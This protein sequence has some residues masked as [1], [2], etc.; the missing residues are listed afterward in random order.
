[1]H[2]ERFYLERALFDPPRGREQKYYNLIQFVF[3]RFIDVHFSPRREAQM[4]KLNVAYQAAQRR[5]VPH[6]Q[7]LN[8]PKQR[9]EYDLAQPCDDREGLEPY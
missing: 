9:S 4:V 3:S 5:Q 8:S 2:F 6:G 7:V 1:M